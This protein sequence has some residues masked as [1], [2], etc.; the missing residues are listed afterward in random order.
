MDRAVDLGYFDIAA[1][2]LQSA[3]D[4][5]VTGSDAEHKF[6]PAVVERELALAGFAQL[7]KRLIG[8]LDEPE[9]QSL[10]VYELGVS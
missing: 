3:C 8:P 5:L 2:E 1:A 7:S 9:H 4:D 10:F 6:G